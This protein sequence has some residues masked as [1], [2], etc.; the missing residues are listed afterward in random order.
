MP[1]VYVDGPP[2]KDLEAKRAMTSEITDALEKAYGL[3]RQAFVV[4]IKENSPENVCVGGELIC[5]RA[6]GGEGA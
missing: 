2:I 5:D 6:A 1:N 4:I 3:P